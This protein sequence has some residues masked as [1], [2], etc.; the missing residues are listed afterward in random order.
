MMFNFSAIL[1][2]DRFGAPLGGLLG[3]HFGKNLVLRSAK[4]LQDPSWTTFFRLL[5]PPEALPDF[6]GAA[7]GPLS[8]PLRPRLAEKVPQEGPRRARNGLPGVPKW[9]PK[10]C[11]I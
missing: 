5:G 10:G 8:R 9:A 6:P 7:F 1:L 11:P 3:G 2:Q 4:S